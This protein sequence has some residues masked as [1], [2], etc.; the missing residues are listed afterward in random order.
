MKIIEEQGN[1]FDDRESVLAHCISSDF[2]MGAGI[3]AAFTNMGVKGYLKTNYPMEWT[4]HGR[5]IICFIPEGENKGQLVANLITKKNV[6]DKPT[7]TAVEEALTSM[8]NQ[9]NIMGKQNICMPYIGCGIDGLEWTKV[10]RIIDS[11]FDDTD[12]DIRVRYRDEGDRQR[13]YF[14]GSKEADKARAYQPSVK[15]IKSGNK[16]VLTI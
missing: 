8:R 11:V 2:V 9:L 16:D 4:G 3:A 10:S 14:T 15:K 7:Y 6:Y 1:V 5:C 12:F 13:A